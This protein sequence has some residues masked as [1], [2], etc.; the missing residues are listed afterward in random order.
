MK[1]N[2]VNILLETFFV[3]LS[4][5]LGTFTFN[6][7]SAIFNSPKRIDTFI[8]EITT[9]WQAYVVFVLGVI[10]LGWII[11]I[12][13]RDDEFDKLLRYINIQFAALNSNV[14]R[15]FEEVTQRIR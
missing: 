12:R 5:S 14:S 1:K 15:G 4:A 8:T 10:L 7:V 13:D 6:H 3:L 2:L 11:W 9:Y